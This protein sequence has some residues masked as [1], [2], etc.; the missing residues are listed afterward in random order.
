MS[1]TTLES[2]TVARWY[3]GMDVFFAAILI[4][5][6]IHAL[7]SIGTGTLR[8]YQVSGTPVPIYQRGQTIFGW[9]GWCEYEAIA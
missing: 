6:L 8:V 9:A 5:Q 3:G 7:Y 1:F 2:C 4:K